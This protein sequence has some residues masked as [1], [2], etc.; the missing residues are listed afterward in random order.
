MV[1][2]YIY[3]YIYQIY[4]TMVCLF[5]QTFYVG[6]LCVY[7]FTFIVQNYL[8][9]ENENWHAI[10]IVLYYR[11]IYDTIFEQSRELF[12]IVKSRLSQAFYKRLIIIQ[13][14][15]YVFTQFCTNSQPEISMFISWLNFIT[16][17]RLNTKYVTRLY[18]ILYVYNFI[19][20]L[21]NGLSE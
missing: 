18:I 6:I 2:I 10:V 4:K 3:I 14:G 8:R 16:L 7:N 19:K 12:L 11:N 20:M 9:G 1:Y 5:S 21:Y 17:C 13:S 15:V